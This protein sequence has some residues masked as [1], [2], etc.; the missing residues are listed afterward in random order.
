M[1]LFP[2]SYTNCMHN[3][4]SNANGNAGN[5]NEVQLKKKVERLE[6]VIEFA[7]FIGIGFAIAKISS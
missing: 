7:L 5:G 1:Y 6:K 4:A 3:F 2:N